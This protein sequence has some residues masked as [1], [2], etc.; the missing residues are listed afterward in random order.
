MKR[1]KV[2]SSN[3]AE[4]G[5]DLP[6]LTLQIKFNSGGIYDYW[7]VS[8]SLY[9]RF[10]TAGSKGKFFWKNIKTDNEINYR[11]VDI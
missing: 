11:R 2:E 4:I 7:P 3:I 10:M 5:Y 6:T 1:E 8:R 9:D